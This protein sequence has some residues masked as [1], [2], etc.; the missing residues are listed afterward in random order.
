MR[1]MAAL[2]IVAVM[3]VACSD[4]GAAPVETPVGRRSDPPPL[5]LYVSNQS[6]AEPEVGVTVTVD[7]EVV[8]DERFPVRD[9]HHVVPFT[10]Y[11]DPGDHTL[12]ATSDSGTEHT[13]EFTVPDDAPWW[14]AVLYWWYPEDGPPEFTVDISDEPISFG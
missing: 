6:Y 14:A 13:V 4:S 8:V 3:V 12:T 11:I 7:G 9:Q 1:R 10:V 5:T 2:T